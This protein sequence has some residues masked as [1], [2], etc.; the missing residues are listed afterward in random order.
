MGKRGFPEK[1]LTNSSRAGYSHVL[2]IEEAHDLA[3]TTLK[4]LKRFWELEDGYKKLP[5]WSG[6]LK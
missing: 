2:M 6:R 3:V 4:Y 5:C 1:I